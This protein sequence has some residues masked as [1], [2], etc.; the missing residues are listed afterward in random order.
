M[1]IIGC[2]LAKLDIKSV[3]G[4]WRLYP[5]TF[6][7]QIIIPL[8]LWLPFTWI[9][10]NEM[11]LIV[12][13]ILSAMPVANSAVLFA[14]TCGGDTELAAKG[15]FITTLFSLITVPVVIMLVT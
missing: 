10:K 3:F 12:T 2:S 9:I 8:L 7:K 14:T 15:V 6:V 5:W 1:L 11:L 13:Y 4:E